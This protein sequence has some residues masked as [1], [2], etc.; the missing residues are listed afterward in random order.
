MKNNYINKIV[1]ALAAVM[2]L[3]G[4][5]KSESNTGAETTVSPATQESTD[6]KHVVDFKAETKEVF[7]EDDLEFELT[8]D[9]YYDSNS[10]EFKHRDT[11]ENYFIILYKDSTEEL[12]KESIIEND[13]FQ[14]SRHGDDYIS[15]SYKYSE[16]DGFFGNLT[17]AKGY[18]IKYQIQTMNFSD[19]FTRM[20]LEF[21]Y[22]NYRVAID[23]EFDKAYEEVVESNL[24]EIVYS[25]SFGYFEEQE[26]SDEINSTNY[27][28]KFHLASDDGYEFLAKAYINANGLDIIQTFTPMASAMTYEKEGERLTSQSHGIRMLQSYS[29]NSNAKNT[30]DSYYNLSLTR[31]K[32]FTVIEEKSGD[33]IHDE[34]RDMAYKKVYFTEHESGITRVAYLVAESVAE[35]LDN[36]G[37]YRFLFVTY[38]QEEIDDNYEATITELSKAF[39][40]EFPVLNSFE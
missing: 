22:K 3:S 4:C 40:F 14:Q 31:D 29:W 11:N 19:D 32:D 5:G 38:I 16:E 10:Y 30:I 35:E 33:T 9:F 25:V 17:T 1:V 34:Q 27:Q 28:T 24:M 18:E 15:T 21:I 37:T 39:D 2:L 23:T 13:E 6:P 36:E 12:M 26:E 8:S 20:R 7:T